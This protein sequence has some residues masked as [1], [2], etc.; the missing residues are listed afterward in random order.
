MLGL[1]NPIS[2]INGPVIHPDNH[3]LLGIAG[4]AYGDWLLITV[5][6]NKGTG[7]VKSQSGNGAH[8]N[9]SVRHGSPNNFA[10]TRPDIVRVLPDVVDRRFPQLDRCGRA[11]FHIAA[12]V[13]PAGP[14]ASST[15]VHTN[16]ETFSGGIRHNKIV[17]SNADRCQVFVAK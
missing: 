15:D 3:I 7:R 6:H 4:R 14:R 10:A 5:Q 16:E 9:P 1:I 8:S 2:L 11:P 17:S 12:L 13:E